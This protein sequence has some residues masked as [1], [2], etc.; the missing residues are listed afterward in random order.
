MLLTLCSLHMLFMLSD[1]LEPDT[2]L[3]LP[4]SSSDIHEN[5]AQYYISVEATVESCAL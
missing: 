1:E 3:Y 2:E 4:F 5:K